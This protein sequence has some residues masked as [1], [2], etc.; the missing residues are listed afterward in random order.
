MA[1]DQNGKLASFSNWD[2]NGNVNAEYEI[3][4]PG[5]NIFSTL[6]GGQYAPWSGTS[7][8]APMVSAAA[9]LLRTKYFDKSVRK[10]RDKYY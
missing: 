5:E 10:V 8:A 9:A 7:M 3:A 1:T 4:A 6:P 2:Y